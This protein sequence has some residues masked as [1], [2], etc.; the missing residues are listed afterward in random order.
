MDCDISAEDYNFE[1]ESGGRVYVC[2]HSEPLESPSAA[3]AILVYFE[4]VAEGG[5]GRRYGEMHLTLEGEDSLRWFAT[6]SVSRG[7]LTEGV[8]R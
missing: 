8:V 2:H 1:V 7:Q 3:D 5:T 6:E 4:C